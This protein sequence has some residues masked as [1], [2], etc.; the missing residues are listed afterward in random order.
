MLDVGPISLHSHDNSRPGGCGSDE[1]VI[2]GLYIVNMALAG[3]MDSKTVRA[4]LNYYGYTNGVVRD[5]L[6][7]ESDPKDGLLAV[8]MN[9]RLL[10]RA[11]EQAE[12]HSPDSNDRIQLRSP[13]PLSAASSAPST[14]TTGLEDALSEDSTGLGDAVPENPDLQGALPEDTPGPQ[15]ALPETP[16]LQGALPE[17][18]PGPQD[19]LPENTPGLRDALSKNTPSLQDALSE[20]PNQHSE[21]L[22]QRSEQSPA[23]TTFLEDIPGFQETTGGAHTDNT[24]PQD[25]FSKIRI[26]QFLDQA[27]GATLEQAKIFLEVAGED[28]EQA[29]LDFGLYES[30]L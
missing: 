27:H 26:Q 14:D 8:G 18:T 16:G 23:K 7:R 20:F 10:N 3:C 25:F 11:L 4:F 24:G 19:A 13:S 6:E 30:K 1:F 2:H 28:V 5:P 29:L 22:R 17:D 15:D 21:E 9:G 12:G